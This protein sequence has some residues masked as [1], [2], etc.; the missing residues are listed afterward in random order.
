MDKHAY[1]HVYQKTVHCFFFFYLIIPFSFFYLFV[2]FFPSSCFLSFFLFCYSFNSLLLPFPLPFLLVLSSMFL[3]PFLYCLFLLSLYFSS[4]FQFHSFS[5]LH[6][7]RFISSSLLSNSTLSSPCISIILSPLLFFQIP[8]FLLPAFLSFYLLSSS[9]KFHPFFSPSFH[10]FLH[11]FL[12]LASHEEITIRPNV[13]CP[14][15][16]MHTFMAYCL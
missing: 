4:S 11:P 8:L 13:T 2:S 3:Y 10:V 16:F 7:H 1:A 5:S 6:F 14:A 12:S 9:F 15:S